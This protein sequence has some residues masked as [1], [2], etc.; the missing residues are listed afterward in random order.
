MKKRTAV[1][2]HLSKV[3]VKP[4]LKK[5]RRRI[6]QFALPT[7]RWN[8]EANGFTGELNITS[9]SGGFVTGTVFGNPIRGWYD[10]NAGKLTFVRFIGGGNVTGI[11]NQVYE[12]Y[13]WRRVGTDTLFTLAGSFI[14]VGGGSSAQKSKFGWVATKTIVG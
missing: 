10:F 12:G 3:N 5:K 13:I 2:A 11:N 4:V 1:K 6:T 9:V 8:I 14:T 7:G